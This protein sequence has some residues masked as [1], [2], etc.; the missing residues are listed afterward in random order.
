MRHF[1]AALINRKVESSP[2]YP[3][4]ESH[5]SD[6]NLLT[7]ILD[8]VSLSID[9]RQLAKEVLEE[10]VDLPGV[11]AASPIELRRVKGLSVSHITAIRC[12]DAVAL[13]AIQ[14]TAFDSPVLAGSQALTN[15]LHAI[16]AHRVTEE[17]R[18]IFLNNKYAVIRDEVMTEGTINS[19][20]AYP[21]EILKRALELGANSI[22]LVHNHPNGDPSP[23]MQDRL[24]TNA[25]RDAAR[26]LEI[27]IHDHIVI[28]RHGHTSFRAM[29]LL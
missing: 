11:L 3:Y 18:V 27:E 9:T 29:G 24:M 14:V 10:F 5:C 17:F 1:S 20:A 6:I 15:Y 12:V 22:I 21:R 8:L 25:V 19:T 4:S 2:S 7:W 23:S 13:R 26:P 28:G 16:M